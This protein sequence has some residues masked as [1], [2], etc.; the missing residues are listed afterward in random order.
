M[1]II[2]CPPAKLRIEVSARF[3]VPL[4]ASRDF[5]TCNL[6]HDARLE[7]CFRDDVGVYFFYDRKAQE[8]NN[9]R[10]FWRRVN[11]WT[12]R[13]EPKLHLHATGRSNGEWYYDDCSFSRRVEKGEGWG[14][15]CKISSITRW[16]NLFGQLATLPFANSNEWFFTFHRFFGY[17]CFQTSTQSS[18]T[19]SRVL[20]VAKCRED[21]QLKTWWNTSGRRLLQTSNT[22]IL[23]FWLFCFRRSETKRSILERRSKHEQQSMLYSPT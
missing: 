9:S 4:L 17:G 12:M 2:L 5:Q 1:S 13:R 21:G 14:S 15:T 6:N 19:N 16:I 11:H 23:H 22:P 7:R 3:H 20:N 18:C 8:W 10:M